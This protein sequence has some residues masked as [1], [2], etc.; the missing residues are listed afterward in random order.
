MADRRIEVYVQIDGEDVLAAELWSHRRRNHESATF[1]YAVDY[2]AHSAAF[3]LDPALPLVDGLQQ[4]PGEREIFGGFSDCAPD[5]WG[6]RLIGRA[7]RPRAEEERQA[8]R[9][10]GE[11]DYL[12]GARDDMR[13]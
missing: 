3:E 2:L 10:L 9:S 6:R 11:I 12:L 4:T 13:Q 1:A 5:R 8:R 7:E